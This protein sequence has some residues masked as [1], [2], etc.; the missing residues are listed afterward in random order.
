[1]NLISS[2]EMLGNMVL[3]WHDKN[4]LSFK[5]PLNEELQLRMFS[6]VTKLVNL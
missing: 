6:H 3:S 5:C 2:Q 4:L 1:M